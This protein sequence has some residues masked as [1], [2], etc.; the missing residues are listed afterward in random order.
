MT[1]LSDLRRLNISDLTFCVESEFASRNDGFVPML[2]TY[3]LT[4]EDL[5]HIT[6]RTRGHLH[7]NGE[8]R[9]QLWRGVHHRRPH[10]GSESI[11]LT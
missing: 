5:G 4:R 8:R 6:H 2:Q 1:N 7:R 3:G 10:P 9:L 11:L